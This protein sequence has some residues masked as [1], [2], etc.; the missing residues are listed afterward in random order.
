MP[1]ALPDHEGGTQVMTVP[2]ELSCHT[3]E[4]HRFTLYLCTECISK[5][6]NP[7]LLQ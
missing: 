6:L 2:P 7:H 4:L 3:E 5:Y 1:C